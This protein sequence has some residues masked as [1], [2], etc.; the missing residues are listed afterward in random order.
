MASLGML[1]LAPPWDGMPKPEELPETSRSVLD[2]NNALAVATADY[3]NI[4]RLIE[5]SKKVGGVPLEIKGKTK[6]KTSQFTFDLYV[7]GDPRFGH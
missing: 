7:L 1:Y 4:E 2:G 6:V 3:R 5:W